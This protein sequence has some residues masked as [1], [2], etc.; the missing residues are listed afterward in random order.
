MGVLDWTPAPSE[1]TYYRSVRDGQRAYLVRRGGK[2]MMRLDREMEEILF[3][4][5]KENLQEWVADRQ[6]H[7]INAYQLAQVTFAADRELCRV[8]GKTIESRKEWLS[9]KEQE[10]VK[11]MEVGPDTGDIRDDLYDAMTGTLRSLVDG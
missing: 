4:V 9:L 6:V 8:M 5:N 1:R 10:R 11:W 7:P 3:P 2:D